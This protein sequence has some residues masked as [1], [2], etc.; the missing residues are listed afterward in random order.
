MQLTNETII[1]LMFL[2][3]NYYLLFSTQ[4]IY[5]EHFDVYLFTLICI[6]I[7]RKLMGFLK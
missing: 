3:T 2:L 7:L 5:F 1:F 6:N 4:L